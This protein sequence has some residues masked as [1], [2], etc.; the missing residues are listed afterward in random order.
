[1]DFTTTTA[2]VATATLVVGIAVWLLGDG[3]LH[4][5]RFVL[6]GG[7]LDAFGVSTLPPRA[8]LIANA[9]PNDGKEEFLVEVVVVDEMTL[10]LVR[11]LH[12]LRAFRQ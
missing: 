11:T 3:V 5:S 7:S 1:M 4:L 2:A 10:A 6:P 12:P 8:D 9:E